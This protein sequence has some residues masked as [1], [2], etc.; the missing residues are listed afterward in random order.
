MCIQLFSGMLETRDVVCQSWSCIGVF[1]LQRL[2]VL[3][4][5][6]NVH[7]VKS[8]MYLCT[9]KIPKY[10]LLFKKVGNRDF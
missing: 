4:T 7:I 2:Q 3:A 1:V 8:H 10:L 5:E 6:A 9:L